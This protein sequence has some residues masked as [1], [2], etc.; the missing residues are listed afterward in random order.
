VPASALRLLARARGQEIP[1]AATKIGAAQQGA[2]QRA[3][4][5]S[6]IGPIWEAN[7]VWLILV[8][9]ILFTA[10]PIGFAVIATVVLARA[11]AGFAADVFCVRTIG[12]QA[13]VV[14]GGEAAVDFLVA[15]FAFLGADVIRA[16]HVWQD[17][18]VA[19]QRAAR[20]GREHESFVCDVKRG[21]F[22]DNRIYNTLAGQ[23]QCAAGQ[24]LGFA[25]LGRVFHC[26]DDAFSTRHHIHRS[27]HAFDL[28]A[29][30]HPVGKIAVG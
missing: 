9:V 20:D 21:K 19:V 6:S 15:L 10:F 17:D 29:R 12:Q 18:G 22:R 26:Y 3:L 23:R 25:I 27:T 14:G 4:I 13:R 1:H 30:D 7:H 16:G 8:I 11:V 24:Y 2:R 5:E 28:F